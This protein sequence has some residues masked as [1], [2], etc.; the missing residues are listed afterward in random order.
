MYFKQVYFCYSLLISSHTKWYYSYISANDSCMYSRCF[1]RLQWN[2]TYSINTKIHILHDVNICVKWRSIF[3]YSYVW[4][5][6]LSI[7]TYYSYTLMYRYSSI[8]VSC[9]KYYLIAFIVCILKYH[10]QVFLRNGIFKWQS[11]WII[12]A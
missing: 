10:I 11:I 12:C 1:V 2:F 9:V 6:V 8:R 5:E 4:C 3:K 7:Y